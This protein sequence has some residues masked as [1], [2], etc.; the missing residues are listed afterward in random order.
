VMHFHRAVQCSPI[1]MTMEPKP[2]ATRTYPDFDRK[3]NFARLCFWIW[4]FSN[5][6]SWKR[7]KKKVLIPIQPCP[8]PAP[9]KKIHG[10]W[11]GRKTPYPQNSAPTRPIATC[12]Y[13]QLAFFHI[14]TCNKYKI[15]IHKIY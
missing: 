11:R 12:T 10:Q 4:I 7:K 1:G 15:P 2:I 5:V 9:S 8:N 3:T 14:K 6:Q 13:G